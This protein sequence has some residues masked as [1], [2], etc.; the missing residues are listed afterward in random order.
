MGTVKER[1]VAEGVVDHFAQFGG[2]ILF[3]ERFIEGRLFAKFTNLHEAQI[4]L[5]KHKRVGFFAYAEET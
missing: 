5:P 4:L 2:A 1:F 3:A